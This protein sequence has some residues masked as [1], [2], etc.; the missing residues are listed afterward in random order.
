MEN[1]LSISTLLMYYKRKDVQEAIVQHAKDKE[2]AVKFGDKGFGKRPDT[3]QYPNDILELARQ[4][5]TSFHASE[6]LWKNPLQLDPMMKRQEIDNLR[7]GWDLVIDIDCQFLDYSKIA[8][9]FIIKALRHHGIMSLTCKFSGNHGFHIAV[10]FEAFPENVHN[11]ETRLLFPE[12][13]RKIAFYLKEMIKKHL[14]KELLKREDIN[15]IAVK[16]GKKFNEIV[17]DGEFDPFTVLSIDTLLISSRHLYRMPYSFNEKSGLVSV[18]IDPESVLDFSKEDAK[19]EKVKISNNLVFIDRSKANP[20]EAKDLIVQ[21][22]DFGAKKQ[23]EEEEKRSSSGRR[24]GDFDALQ[25]AIPVEFFP[26]CIKAGLKGMEDGKKRF[27]FML[28][29]FLSSVGWDHD[30]I[31]KELHEWNK[32]NKDQ[33]RETILVGQ[34]RYHKQQKKKIL[35][36]NC[37][38]GMYYKDMHICLP[39]NLCSRVK[40]PVNYSK[41]KVYYL[42]REKDKTNK[43][44]TKKSAKAESPEKDTTKKE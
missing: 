42:N 3:I 12:A 43:K 31:E 7:K 17:K 44:K 15:K 11:M 23:K 33:L 34:L 18:P 20:N 28:V 5:A 1:N 9:D 41:R 22:F 40:N 39:D 6:E 26:P 24:Y 27:M 30:Q 10:P 16:S 8:G 37:D 32:R 4:G 14:A 21:A 19:P 35:P 36:P 38:N 29:N 13:P 25:E 2:V